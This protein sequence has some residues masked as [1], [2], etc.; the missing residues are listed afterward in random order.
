MA[1]DTFIIVT[2]RNE[3]D[4]IEATLKALARAFPEAPVWVA[5]DGSTDATAELA[6]SCGAQVVSSGRPLGKGAAATLAA[7]AAIEHVRRHDRIGQ[8]AGTTERRGDAEGQNDGVVLLCDGDLGESAELLAPLVDA[9]RGGR[10]D[11]AVASFVRRVGGGL[12]VALGFARWAIHR[13]CGL[14]LRAP[15][16]GQ[17]TVRADALDRLLPFGEGFGM[18]IGMTIAAARAG[19]RVAEVELDVS[20]R[21]TGRTPAGFAHRARQLR[22]FV[23]V[24]RSTAP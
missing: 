2:A 22:D 7:R 17:R 18:E 13:R 23:K 3:A 9:V 4:R 6:R 15:I 19:L 16:S 20:H 11:L 24:Y 12:G 8:P 21:A 14:E 5:D 10:C 1:A